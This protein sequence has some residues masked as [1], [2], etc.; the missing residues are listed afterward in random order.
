MLLKQM[1]LGT[2]QPRPAHLLRLNDHWAHV[3]YDHTDNNSYENKSH[4]VCPDTLED[5]RLC[6]NLDVARLLL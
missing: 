5:V 2:I 3:G 6:G 1:F 4:R